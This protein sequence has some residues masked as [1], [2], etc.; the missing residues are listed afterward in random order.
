MGVKDHS[1]VILDGAM[2]T[3]LLKLGLEPG[4]PGEF[5]NIEAPEKVVQ[6]HK[7]YIEAG[8]SVIYANTFGISSRKLK[9]APYT[10]EELLC[11][12]V[13]NA[14]RARGNKAVKIALAMGSL[15]EMLEP[16]GDLSFEEC[17]EAYREQVVIGVKEG[18]DL[19]VLETFT[20]LYELKAAILAV[21]ENSDLPLMASMSFESNG[22][23]FNGCL[24]ESFAM[25]AESLGVDVLGINCSMGPDGI[26]PLIERI[27][28][29]T[30]LPL[31][32]KANAGLPNQEGNYSMSRDKF[33]SEMIKISKLGVKYLGGCCGTDASYIQLLSKVLTDEICPERKMKPTVGL[34]S[35]TEMVTFDE[36][37]TVGER[38]N[39]A[40]REDLKSALRKNDYLPVVREAI[41]QSDNCD[42]LDVNLSVPGLDEAKLMTKIVKEIQGVVDLP[43]QID[44]SNPA[45]LEAGLR[46]V[47]GRPIVNSVTGDRQS[48]DRVFP[49][50]KKYGALCIGLCYDESGIPETAE[51]RYRVA[52]KIL[53]GAESYGISR[54]H[55]IIDALALPVGAKPEAAAVTLKTIELLH[56]RL[57]VKTALGISNVSFGLPMREALNRDFL[58]MARQR[59]LDLAIVNPL[60]ESLRESLITYDILMGKDIDL[61]NIKMKKTPEKDLKPEESPSVEVCL[62][63]G[64]EDSLLDI[65]EEQLEHDSP[66]EVIE[67][68]L[69]PA[70]DEIGRSYEEGEIFLPHLIRAASTVGTAFNFLKAKM[71]TGTAVR[72]KGE[73]LLATVE[74][75]I[76]DIGKNI[77]KVILE[78]YGYDVVDLGK[79]VPVGK[80]IKEAKKRNIKLIGLSALMS[81]TLPNMKRTI[82]E[83][84][85]WDP[86]VKVMVGG[87][88]LT[89]NYARSLGADYYVSD[90]MEDVTI[91]QNIFKND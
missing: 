52:E 58:T 22:R 5:L 24:P 61:N 56:N 82:S 50:V 23:S 53:E 85:K 16:V 2:G 19:I 14:K 43:L 38:I 20:D 47:N 66:M 35:P 33:V 64:L 25:T 46:V 55:I 1:F 74:G 17:Y 36:F 3:S 32:V 40:G 54:D 81:T 12:G 13:K 49:L 10:M 87:A 84:R 6:V 79:D 42:I 71:Q 34:C 75:D 65:V 76:H 62:R 89:E 80:V 72:S 90:A 57:G 30:E 18:V 21:K 78:N 29:M 51:A 48:M 28:K 41:L 83:L 70:L 44:S 86:T 39:P 31:L 73:I 91:A 68:L 45:V 77:A 9:D 67:K 27:S 7:S 4:Y 63:K 60:S 15:G 69:I 59:G 26:Y 8:S 37:V 88:V 11:A